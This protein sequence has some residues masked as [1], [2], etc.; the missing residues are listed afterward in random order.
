MKKIILLLLS[1]ALPIFAQSDVFY[2]SD[3]MPL[4]TNWAGA[5]TNFQN[6]SIFEF[7]KDVRT[8]RLWVQ[9][10]GTHLTS[11]GTLRF[12]FAPGYVSSTNNAPPT[13]KQTNF[14]NWASS[15]VYVDVATDTNQVAMGEEWF[16][17]NGV[18]YLRH[19]A[20]IN[21]NLFVGTTFVGR[22]TYQQHTR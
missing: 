10:T 19:V 3:V 11:N 16:V 18:R 15:Y 22:V 5:G 7:K 1:L 9:M 17:G 21:T 13:N 12:V 8:Y 14:I 20:T 4:G 2:A 6:G